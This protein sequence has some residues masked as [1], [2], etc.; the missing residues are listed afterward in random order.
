MLARL[1]CERTP[2]MMPNMAEQ[3]TINLRSG[4]PIRFPNV[5]L[6]TVDLG[7]LTVGRMRLEPGWR[8]STHMQPMV[9][10]E[11]CQ[12]R[13]VGLLLS[14]RMGVQRKDGTE[15]I[16]EA[17]DVYHIEPGHDGYTIGDEPIISIEWSGLKPWMGHLGVPRNRLLR[18]LL[19]TDLVGSTEKLTQIGDHAW[20]SLLSAHFES[21]RDQV[22]RHGGAE[23]KTTGDGMLATFEGPLHAL[24]CAAAIARIAE[25]DDLSVRSG[26]HVGEVEFIDGDVR[27]SAVHETARIMSAANGSE[28]LVSE[29]TRTLAASG[30]RFVDRG[31]HALKG[32]EGPVRLFAYVT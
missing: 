3:P 5:T 13:H 2:G 8:W 31:E 14:G 23:I 17:D 15:F 10:G 6:E 1:T 12:A 11:W 28:I 30:A 29:I 32:F 7:D 20:R 25:Q 18:T 9:G 19:F 4:E 16:V 27:G 21:A 26:V 22:N 24:H